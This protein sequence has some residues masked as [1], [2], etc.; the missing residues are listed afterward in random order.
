MQPHGQPHGQ[1]TYYFIKLMLLAVTCSLSG[2]MLQ[3]QGLSRTGKALMPMSQ[4]SARSLLQKLAEQRANLTSKQRRKLLQYRLRVVLCARFLGR[5]GYPHT[6]MMISVDVLRHLMTKGIPR[7]L[8]I[9]PLTIPQNPCARQISSSFFRNEYITGYCVQGQSFPSRIV[10]M[11]AHPSSLLIAVTGS[12]GKVW[13]GKTDDPRNMYC[14]LYNPSNESMFAKTCEFHPLKDILFIGITGYILVYNTSTCEI[15]QRVRFHQDPGYFCTMPPKFSASKLAC[16]P[17]GK[18]ITAIS[19]SNNG[20]SRA[21][22]VDPLTLIVNGETRYAYLCSFQKGHVPP[23]CSC[24]SPDGSVE[25]TGHTGGIIMIRSVGEED[26]GN[27]FDLQLKKITEIE[28]LKKDLII[29]IKFH[30]TDNS[31]FA[32]KSR[33]GTNFFSSDYAVHLLKIAPDGSVKIIQTFLD[34]SDS[35]DFCFYEKWFLVS[36]GYSIVFYLMSVDNIPV[37]MTEFWSQGMIGSFLLNRVNGRDT[38]HYSTIYGGSNPN[39]HKAVHK[40]DITFE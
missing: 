1:H 35:D 32:M 40:A 27:G 36:N 2:N 22:V 33:S 29:S 28:S 14:L 39:L 21:F 19:D 4:E 23:L 9:T 37:K 38:L 24:F 7:Q 15:L 34:T 10:Y 31:V 30:S 11:T 20:L 17:T 25:A 8:R 6:K 13:I 26:K 3:M 18:Y 5:K 12:D 16:H